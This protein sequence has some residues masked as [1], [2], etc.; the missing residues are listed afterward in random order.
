MDVQLRILIKLHA[1]R[2]VTSLPTLASKEF[3][4]FETGLEPFCEFQRRKAKIITIHKM[5]INTVPQ[6]LCDTIAITDKNVRY[7]TRNEE[8]YIVPK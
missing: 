4:Y 8:K 1:A 6:Y 7:K 5:N 3:L 2:I